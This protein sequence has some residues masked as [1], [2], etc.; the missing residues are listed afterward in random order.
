MK[1]KKI[2]KILKIKIKNK[3][4]N[5]N[6]N[7]FIEQ[8]EII[9]LPKRE[10]NL[11]PE[12]IIPCF[13]HGKYILT[14]L[15]SI[16]INIPITIINDASTDNSLSVIENLKEK[17]KFKLINN[18][19][20][21]NQAASINKAVLDSS[22]NLFIILNADDALNNLAINTILKIYKKQKNIR[23]LGAG[24]ISFCDESVIRFNES[25]KNN[26]T[27]IPKVKIYNKEI[28]KTYKKPNDINMTMSGFSFLRSAWQTVGGFYEYKDRICSFDDRDF[29]MRVSAIFDV[30]IIEEPLSF[31]RT[32]SSTGLGQQ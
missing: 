30:G 32:T 19:K 12:I 23:A 5:R 25:I 15:S 21:I 26:L 31:Y 16:N 1:I 7:R 6:I 11:N 2:I 13:N 9:N 27:Y 10:E 4:I 29:Q 18:K 22:N 20:N 8:K 14:A 17:F 3:N 28:A 24:T